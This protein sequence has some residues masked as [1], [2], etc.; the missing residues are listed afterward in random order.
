MQKKG[1]LIAGDTQTVSIPTPAIFPSTIGCSVA[2]FITPLNANTSLTYLDPS[3]LITVPLGPF[4]THV[5]SLDFPITPSI[6]VGTYKWY[7]RFKD[8]A[9]QLTTITLDPNLVEIIKP[10]DE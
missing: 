6:A 10:G 5:T 3:A 9:N 4:T 1:E 7:A 2:L 8:T